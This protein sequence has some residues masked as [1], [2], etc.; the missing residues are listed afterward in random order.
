MNTAPVR[1]PLRDALVQADLACTPQ[2]LAIYDVLMHATTHPT[3]EDVYQTVRSG[4][5]T[6]SRDTVYRTLTLFE[7]LGLLER[8]QMSADCARFEP[9]LAPHHH[10]VCTGCGSVADFDWHEVESLP[11]PALPEGW[12]APRRAHV[13]FRSMCPA[14]RNN[15]LK[16]QQ[17]SN[18]PQGEHHVHDQD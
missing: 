18:I 2:R 4:M 15:A 17:K 6:I 9:N 12:D 7:E 1:T 13:V 8:V 3:A 11:P 14:C 5:P 10:L 16:Q